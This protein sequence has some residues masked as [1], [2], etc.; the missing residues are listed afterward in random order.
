MK[1]N[2][3]RILAALA[4]LVGLAIPMGVW[5]QTTVTFT[6]E[7]DTGENSVTK[8]GVT[9]SM[10]TMSRTDNY[11]CYANSDMSVAST[12]G[13]ITS[14]VVT[15][16]ANGTAS[17]GPGNFSVSES[18][19]G[20]YTYES[21]GHTG[22]WSGNAARLA[23]HASA[24]VR[25]TQIVVTV[26]GSAPATFTVNLS[27]TTGGT[28]SANP[29]TATEG[30]TITL[31]ATPDDDYIFGSW[32]IDPSTVTITDNQFT[33]PASDVT[34][35]ASW[36]E[37]GGGSTNIVTY[38]FT[39]VDNFL[40]EYPGSTH[41][42][43]GEAIDNF[44][45]LS[46]EHFVATANDNHKFNPVS[47]GSTTTYFFLGKSGATLQLPAFDF[48]V[49]K[50][51]IIGRS[52]ASTSVVQNIYVGEVAVSTATTGAT[53]TN[54][55]E[56]ADAYQAAGTVYT[57]KV[58]SSHNTQITAINVYEKVAGSI[59]KPTLPASCN[60][61]E[62]MQ[63]EINNTVSGATVRYTTDGTDPTI[64]T[65]NVYSE[66]F[67]I[68]STTTV[69][70]IAVLEGNASSVAE[71]TYTRVYTITLNQTTGGTISASSAQAAE[72]TTVTLT[73]TPN[74][75]YT[76]GSWSVTPSVT[77][78]G[79]SFTMPANNVTVSATFTA[80]ETSCTVSF[81]VNN[82][83][84][85]TATTFGGS[86]DLTKFVANVTTEGYTFAGW[87]TAATGGT[88]IDDNYTP[89]GDVT[90]YAQFGEI[91]PSDYTLVTS[92]SDLH[93]GDMVV[94]A[95]SAYPEA[96]STEQKT[97]N[98][99]EW[100]IEK[101]NNSIS[102][103]DGAMYTV[104]EF[105]LGGSSSGWSFY[106]AVNNGYI[107][108]A[109]TKTSGTNYLRTKS[110]N[111]S[112]GLWTISIDGTTHKA[113][114]VSV[115]NDKTPYLKYNTGG[116]FAC[117]NTNSQS[118]VVLYTK[119]ASKSVKGNRDDIEATSKV[120]AIPANV[121]VTVKTDGIVYL[122]G[123]NNGNEANLIVEDGG[124]LVASNNVKGTMLK[125]ITGYGTAT[126]GNYYLISTPLTSSTEPEDVG[127]MLSNNYDLY[128][129]NQNPSDNLEWRNY[130][131]GNG[132]NMYVGTGYLY[133]NSATIDLEFAGT[134]RES[135]N[136]ET[137]QK[138]I[139]YQGEQTFAGWNLVGNPYPCNAAVNIA[140]YKMN[141]TNEGINVNIMSIGDVIAPMEGVFV[142]ATQGASDEKVT[143]TATT[144]AVTT[145]GS[146]GIALEVNRDNVMLDRAIVGM[147]EGSM[148]NKLRLSD[149][150]TE[151]YIPQ[152]D[153]DYA[154]VSTNGQGEM[155][156]SFK[157]SRNATYTISANTENV[158]MNY[159]HLIDNMTGA[160]VDLLATPNYTFE[161]RTNDYTSR[162]RLVFS[163]NGIDEQT[164]ETFAYFNGTNW[165][166][167][168][169]GDATLQV[170]DIIG[171]IV[172]SETIN[173]N[174]TVSLNQ[175]AGIY[176]LRL[177]N[178]NDV[179]VQKVVVR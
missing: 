11:R 115:G 60:F 142:M 24:Q 25:M 33:M 100:D 154:L 125:S 70:A 162:F 76:F 151:L 93:A 94:I 122:T 88:K 130:R 10:S 107:Y 59:T 51:E 26:G 120:T 118:D 109:G 75:G 174:A 128:Y 13:N 126:S 46:G 7:T 160:D 72:G 27:Q 4:L 172:S 85:M 58:T 63:V 17:Y 98:R 16:T 69:K 47:T 139:Y 163:A 148:V 95:A 146:K 136:G 152:G 55:Y 23:L 131:V 20:I 86:I 169:T 104:C 132:F 168:N 156:V 124:Q 149:G 78:N 157:A 141:S 129:F 176:M 145:Q 52:G 135:T 56:I 36:T 1:R 158:D 153:K 65:G 143:F 9:V 49:E 12:V 147:S 38:D 137:F 178:G 8:D 45:S 101:S 110:E 105:E 73:A 116:M 77:L 111:D 30:T 61:T 80:S 89:A 43:I 15:C 133:A 57:L 28:I 175:P 83:V 21:N 40:T 170:V 71:A 84:E 127:Q 150:V 96:M 6:A 66:P 67:T 29:T 155:P 164:A 14:V 41:P 74:V 53:G 113:T 68:T 102:W 42:T 44:Y 114:I 87:Y 103:T 108:A 173:G 123:N 54:V 177:V 34:V 39:T 35:S 138:T 144:D 50:I 121:I 140:F 5:G 37:N 79:D 62:S 171:R 32:S 159:L 90:V 81:S 97:N 106:D 48:D 119:P 165:T 117:Y 167:S 2:F 134:L 161:A 3:T 82:K 166:V 99:G 22:T 92:E 91:V 31:T 19:P 112:N 179:K 18:N 64:N